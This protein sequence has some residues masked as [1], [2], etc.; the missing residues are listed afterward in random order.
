[1]MA[2]PCWPN[3]GPKGGA[4]VA[5]PALRLTLTTVFIFFVYINFLDANDPN[6]YSNDT[7]VK[8]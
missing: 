4:G 6:V 5:S 8:Y 1:M 2:T 3:A 7:N